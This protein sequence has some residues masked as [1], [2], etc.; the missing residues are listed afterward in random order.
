MQRFAFG[1]AADELEHDVGELPEHVDGRV[2]QHV[3]SL[4]AAQV[5]DDD[6]RAPP[7]PL[8]TSLKRFEIESVRYDCD[9]PRRHAFEPEALGGGARIR[10]NLVCSAVRRALHRDLSRRLVG[11]DLAA[12]ADPDRYAGERRGRQSEDVRVELC[13]VDDSDFPVSA[14]ARESPHV[15]QRVRRAEAFD[16]ELDDRCRRCD[17]AF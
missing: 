5:R 14:P 9:L 2:E 6:D 15:T 8:A 7:S 16:R 3:V 12:V 13:A 1:T 4:F 11:V 10:D 17:D